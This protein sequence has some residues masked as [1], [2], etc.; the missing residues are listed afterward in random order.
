MRAFTV[1]VLVVA[2]VWAG[3]ATAAHNTDARWLNDDHFDCSALE[4]TFDGA[5]A[6][7]AEQ[8][9]TVATSVGPLDIVAPR[10][11]ASTCVGP[12]VPTS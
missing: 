2:C 10:H 8:Q 1:G 6:A 4:V 3:S 7:R 12:T 11:G 5:T 9:L